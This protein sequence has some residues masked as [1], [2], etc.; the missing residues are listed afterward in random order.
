MAA[1]ASGSDS[2]ARITR[3]SSQRG[4]PTRSTSPQPSP[5]SFTG[6]LH[7][8]PIRAPGP[9]CSTD[10]RLRDVAE[11]YASALAKGES[12]TLAVQEE[13]SCSHSNAA[14]I[15]LRVRRAGWLPPTRRGE[16]KA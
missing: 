2:D 8:S 12:P 10:E 4:C 6:G 9:W 15:V 13:L 14:K 1:N 3:A 11:V 16:A 7:L 5:S